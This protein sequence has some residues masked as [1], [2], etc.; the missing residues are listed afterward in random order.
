ML[1]QCAEFHVELLLSV[2]LKV[3]NCE[4]AYCT[5]C[6][7]TCIWQ[8]YVFNAK[9]KASYLK[10]NAHNTVGLSNAS[11]LHQQGTTCVPIRKSFTRHNEGCMGDYTEWNV[12]KLPSKTSSQNI[13]HVIYC[14]FVLKGDHMQKKL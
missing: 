8:I 2:P 4:D 12:C 14:S 11:S 9:K 10:V 7:C 1:G 6:I 3:N 5:I 13:Q